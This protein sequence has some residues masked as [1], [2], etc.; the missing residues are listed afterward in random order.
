MTCI[1]LASSRVCAIRGW[2]ELVYMH[3]HR[4]A[5]RCVCQSKGFEAAVAV[6]IAYV[7]T[8]D[9][10]ARFATTTATSSTLTKPTHYDHERQPASKHAKLSLVSLV[11]VGSFIGK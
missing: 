11:V 4:V 2:P 1:H 7:I 3:S 6:T 9:T 5:Q 8:Q 10:K